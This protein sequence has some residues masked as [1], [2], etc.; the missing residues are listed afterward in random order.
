VKQSLA[1]RARDFDGL[2]ISDYGKGFVSQELVDAVIAAARAAG[3]VIAVDPNPHNPLNWRGVTS[4]KPNRIEAFREIGVPESLWESRLNPVDDELLLRVGHALLD[5]WDV[6]MVQITL[7]EQGM[8]LFERGGKTHYIPT[9]AREVFDVSGAGD[10][11]VA[12]F[13]LSLTAGA[14]PRQAAEISNYASGV[15]VGKL[16]T[17]TLTPQELADAMKTSAF[18]AVQL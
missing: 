2:I 17:A 15:V 13:T 5:R 11:A 9:V 4:V 10:T 16:G 14:S 12:L 6:R 7:G 1:E 3:L 18:A 8:M